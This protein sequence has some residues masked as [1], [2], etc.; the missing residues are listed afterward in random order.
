MHVASLTR[1]IARA[2]ARGRGCAHRGWL[3]WA[4]AFGGQ[5]MS[6]LFGAVW[7]SYVPVGEDCLLGTTC[8]LLAV[9]VNIGTVALGFV[10]ALY[11]A[12]RRK[13]TDD[14]EYVRL[15]QELEDSELLGS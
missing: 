15:Q 8:Y 5:A 10:V 13:P 4:T 7:D 1:L 3:C 14:A 11:F 2:R 9:Y 6:S 12:W